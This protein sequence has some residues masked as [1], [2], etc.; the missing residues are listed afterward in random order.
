[1]C[2]SCP[3]GKGCGIGLYPPAGTG[4]STPGHA[5]LPPEPFPH[6]ADGVPGKNH[7]MSHKCHFSKKHTAF[8]KRRLWRPWPLK[9]SVTRSQGQLK[10]SGYGKAA[11]VPISGFQRGSVMPSVHAVLPAYP[12]MLRR[13]GEASGPVR[14]PLFAPT[15]SLGSVGRHLGSPQRAPWAPGGPDP[16]IDTPSVT[17]FWKSETG[18]DAPRGVLGAT[19]GPCVLFPE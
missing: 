14:F 13:W 16:G 11:L 2:G 1:M 17:L 12:S 5:A 3:G 7:H 15:P 6:S 18:R 9:F 19:P 4:N 10:T 8:R